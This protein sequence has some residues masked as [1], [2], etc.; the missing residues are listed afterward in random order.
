MKM[1][2]CHGRET[3]REG[4]NLG[5]V[6]TP[7]GSRV[8]YASNQDGPSSIYWRAADGNGVPER[9]TTP[10]EGAQNPMSWSSDGRTLAFAR[11]L[12]SDAALWTLSLD[13]G[14]EPE[15]FYD[16]PDGSDQ[17]GAAFSPNGRWL[18][19][20]SDEAG[21]AEGQVYVLPF[22]ATGVEPRQITQNGGVH[23]R[24]SPAGTACLVLS[25]PLSQCFV[26]GTPG[27]RGCDHRGSLCRRA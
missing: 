3:E 7:D 8:T 21:E 1:P 10:G 16:I 20:H 23:P 19:F 24:W 27:G 15:L 17:R 26:R 11:S 6:W 12:R 2:A 4:A 18:A 22:P 13:D 5:H 14:T 25:T 9:L